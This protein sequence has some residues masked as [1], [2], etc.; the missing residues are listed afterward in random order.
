MR[1]GERSFQQPLTEPLFSSQLSCLHL[2]PLFQFFSESAFDTLY[3]CLCDVPTGLHVWRDPQRRHTA[4]IHLILLHS[5]SSG[6]TGEKLPSAGTN[7]GE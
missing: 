1:S 7:P 4:G 5:S 6:A 2:F 3:T